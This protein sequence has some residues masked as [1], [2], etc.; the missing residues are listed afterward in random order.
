MMVIIEFT[1]TV[2]RAIQP[3]FKDFLVNVPFF[4]LLM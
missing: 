1:I 2:N 3:I 4:L